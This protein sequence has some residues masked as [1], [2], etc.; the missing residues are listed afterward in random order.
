MQGGR[1]TEGV[2]DK[3]PHF[4]LSYA[5]VPSPVGD[6][7]A[8]RPGADKDVRE[9]YAALSRANASGMSASSA[10]SVGYLDGADRAGPDTARALHRCRRFV[11]LITRRYF[12]DVHCGRQWYACTHRAT[13]GALIPALWTPVPTT[14]R[15]VPS[16]WNCPCP[17]GR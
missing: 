5:T 7:D 12:T 10:S 4:F 3:A 6:V 15:P 13:R 8:A 14:A 16:T 9:F 11:P 2:R 1:S 17:N